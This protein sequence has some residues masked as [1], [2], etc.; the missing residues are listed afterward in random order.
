[1]GKKLASGAALLLLGWA[2]KFGYNAITAE[3]LD[4]DEESAIEWVAQESD[5]VR[6]EVAQGLAEPALGWLDESTNAT[7]EAPPAQ[8]RELID[9]FDA[10]GAESQW[11]VAIEEFAGA[12]LS[13]TLAVELPKPGAA[14][15]RIFEIEAGLWGEHGEGTPDVGQDYLVISFD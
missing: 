13:D 8:L 12:R 10:A 5:W 4:F 9:A 6:S 2:V 11:M 1:M 7:F 14:R 3:P 15:D